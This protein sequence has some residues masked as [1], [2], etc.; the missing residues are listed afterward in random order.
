MSIEY[1]WLK[2]ILSRFQR[3]SLN[4]SYSIFIISNSILEVYPLSL[5]YVT[6]K[7]FQIAMSTEAGRIKRLTTNYNLE[8]SIQVHTEVTT[9]N[10]AQIRVYRAVIPIWHKVELD[11]K[12]GERAVNS[13]EQFLLFPTSRNIPFE[14]S[15]K[16]KATYN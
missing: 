3:I 1:I 7:I 14:N 13:R 6:H 11:T 2:I 4:F 9:R 5:L 10:L 16:V 15:Q 12:E 8:R